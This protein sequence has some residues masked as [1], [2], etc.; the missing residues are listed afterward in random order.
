MAVVGTLSALVLG[1]LISNANT[2]FSER[3]REITVLSAN[4]LR[5]DQALRS[6]GRKPMRPEGSSSNMPSAKPT[7]CFRNIR[8]TASKPTT[9]QPIGCS[10]DW[11]T[12]CS[13]CSHPT[14]AAN[15]GWNRR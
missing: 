2:A 12:P 3:N 13:R 1:L 8:A 5:L 10:Y 11:R 15:G 4:I 9:P 14:R 6:Y 7:T